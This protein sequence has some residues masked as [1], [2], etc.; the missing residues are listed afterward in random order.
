MAAMPVVRWLKPW[1]WAPVTAGRRRP[2]GPRR[3]CRSGR[4]GSCSRCRPSPGRRSGRRKV[5]DDAGRVGA[6][7]AVGRVGVVDEDGE[8]LVVVAGG[9]GWGRRVRRPAGRPR[10]RPDGRPL[11]RGGGTSPAGRV[12]GR[13]S[14]DA[15]DTV[16]AQHQHEDGGEPGNTPEH[17]AQ[18]EREH[19]AAGEPRVGR[20]AR[21]RTGAASRRET[22]DAGRGAW[23]AAGPRASRTGREADPTGGRGPGGGGRRRCGSTRRTRRGRGPDG[24]PRVGGN[25]RSDGGRRAPGRA[26][27]ARPM[28]AYGTQ[29][30]STQAE[31][32]RQ[33]RGYGSP[34]ASP[35]RRGPA[36]PRPLRPAAVR[37]TRPSRAHAQQTPSDG[38]ER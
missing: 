28:G 31:P 36:V 14:T 12:R 10:P 22:A 16:D 32:D 30:R 35:P 17:H 11:V 29:R 2:R 27:D 25:G 3:W 34:P 9:G 20:T 18:D 5:A 13:P 7:V 4:R 38:Q 26:G 24:V 37:S 21:G 6:V 15:L 8:H 23:A 33:P 1:V 19:H